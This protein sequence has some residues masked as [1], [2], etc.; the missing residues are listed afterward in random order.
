MVESAGNQLYGHIGVGTSRGVVATLPPDQAPFLKIHGCWSDPS[1]TIWA[2]G[3]V[4]AEPTRTRLTENAEWLTFRLLDKDI[5]IVGFWTDWD[6]L[7]AVLE[8][9]LGAVSPARIIVV[10]PCESEMLEAKAP[11]LFALGQRAT[12]EFV[13]VQSS[14]DTFLEALR[15]AFSKGFIRQTLRQAAAGYA[16]RFGEQANVQWFEAG[17]SDA[18]ILWRMRRDLEGCDPNQPAKLRDPAA[19][20]LLGLTILQLKRRGAVDSVGGYFDLNGTVVRVLRASNRPLHEVEQAFSRET[21]PA[22]APDIAIAVGAESLNVPPNIAR[23]TAT[24]S[25][26]RGASCTWLSRAEAIEK[27]AL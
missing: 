8:R 21:P 25:I 11:A 1:G 20:P 9:T 18:T 7:N 5:V 15:I 24:G 23:N 27:L 16:H 10:D 17:S 13:H 22:T 6:Y 4:E 2:R 14:G 26:A 12:V 3:Q 19:E